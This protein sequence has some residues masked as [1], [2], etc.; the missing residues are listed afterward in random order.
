VRFAT[1]TKKRAGAR[2]PK[3]APEA[4]RAGHDCVAVAPA[5]GGVII[6]AADYYRQVA[7]AIES[8]ESYVLITGWQLESSVW[9][10]RLPED[11]GRPR[12]LA[13]VVRAAVDRNPGL[14][15]YINAWDYSKIY[16]L[17]REWQ[18]DQKLIETARGRLEFIYD[19]VH[20]PGASHHTKLV[21]ADGHTAWVGGI[22][23]CEHRWDERVHA[24]HHPMRFDAKKNLYGPY[25]DVVAVVRGPV[26]RHLVE[27]FVERWIDAGGE[28]LVLVPGREPTEKPFSHVDLGTADVA[29]SR[30]RGA[31]VVPPRE[32][33][34][35]I[36]T[37]HVEA[38]R[39]AKQLIYIESQ[40]ITSRAVFQAIIERM[41][42]PRMPRLA[43]VIVMPKCLEGR[44]EKVAIEK[45]QQM[46]LAAIKRVAGEQHHEVG[47][48]APCVPSDDDDGRCATYVH[49]KMMIID[50][51]FMTI[52]SANATNRSMG[53]DSEVNLSWRAR[54]RGDKVARGI[55][56]TRVS[57]LT[58]HTGLGP[59]EA[60]EQL[61]P[62]D[63]LVA[64]LDGLCDAKEP[65][66]LRHEVDETVEAG[67]LDD[68]LASLGDP[69]KAPVA[70]DI[71]EEI[72]EG[73]VA[74]VVSV[75]AAPGSVPSGAARA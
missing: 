24:S 29:I 58:E 28:P 72:P 18:T 10:R 56:G 27:H 48:Y 75:L 38:I 35:E 37:L 54:R 17:D 45:P 25:H 65:R 32:A 57:L 16:T 62:I 2:K 11:E 55:L 49:T 44:M 63:G 40:Y 73:L 74:R 42:D 64:R 61:M 14:K 26:V 33:I 34:R 36:R 21:V 4:F 67:P 15:L 3:R 68:L 60:I 71:F 20:A 23:I 53:L 69:E 70:E 43:V 66:I 52:G 51:R 30:T 7:D 59:E 31:T 39:R 1:S 19:R 13:E 22:D 47:I 41:R 46:G 12:T 8:A 6:D 9:M 5:R 50:D